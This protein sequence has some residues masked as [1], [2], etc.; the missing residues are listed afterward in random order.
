MVN[1]AYAPYAD[2]NPWRLDTIMNAEEWKEVSRWYP[3]SLRSLTTVQSHIQAA[4]TQFGTELPWW[5]YDEEIGRKATLE[6]KI[7]S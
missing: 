6:K 2:E 5:E 1:T 3:F 4:C 7:L